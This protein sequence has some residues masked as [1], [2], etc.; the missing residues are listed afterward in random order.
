MYH[1]QHVQ[2]PRKRV[3]VH[4]NRLKRYHQSEDEHSQ[5]D[6]IILPSREEQIDETV[7]P[8]QTAQ[9][10]ISLEQAMSESEEAQSPSLPPLRR[11]TRL[12]KHPERYGTFV[13]FRDSDSELEN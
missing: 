5:E 7:S 11:S 8:L 4:A 6:W 10:D 13:S 2:N 3:V 12:R 9:E 1:I